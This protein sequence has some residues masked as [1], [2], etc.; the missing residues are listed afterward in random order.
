MLT[1][2]SIAVHHRL[3]ESGIRL[4]DA[5]TCVLASLDRVEGLLAW[6]REKAAGKL[7]YE[8]MSI[9]RTML[10]QFYYWGIVR[11]APDRQE[12]F[13][14]FV[15]RT[16]INRYAA[17]YEEKDSYK[18]DV[19]IIVIGYNH[20]DYTKTCVASILGQLPEHFTWELILYNH[21]SSDGTGEFFDSIAGAKTI[22]IAVNGAVPG[23]QFQAV[24]GRYIICVTNDVIV[25]SNALDNLCRALQE[26]PDYGWV[27]PSTPN[28]SNR[29]EIPAAY[30]S[31]EGFVEF[32][33][34][35]NVYD[36]RRQEQRVRLCDPV[37]AFRTMDGRRAY[38]EN[39]IEIWCCSNMQSFPDD[40][41]S[42]AMRRKGLKL[43]LAKDAYCHHF[44]SVTL[45]DDLG[46]MQRQQE[47]Y[48]EG[49]KAFLLRWGVDPWGTGFCYSDV[50]F[51]TW[52][53]HIQDN[54]AVLGINCGLGANSLKVKEIL[55]EGGASGT[56]LYNGTAREEYLPDLR[57][58]SDRAFLVSGLSDIQK[59]REG[60]I[61]IMA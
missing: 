58:I 19:S 26:H 29:Q 39:Y 12:E 27:V 7:E 46:S 11:E 15:Q 49:R 41:L 22:D 4:G 50:L 61:L 5:C 47:F 14:R 54:C 60:T 20:L 9:L 25:G 16:G 34:E 31:V 30:Q 52:A 45:K 28:V 42:L 44:G 37:S 33:R 38:E 2:Q 51:Q 24:Q 6:N 57:A 21:G 23:A 35:N 13:R 10:L 36:E 8:L 59:I 18:Y 3:A 56:I 17:E 40:K 48:E 53:I 1:L 55:R 32:A 43:I